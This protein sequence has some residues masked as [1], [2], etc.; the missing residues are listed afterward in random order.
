MAQPVLLAID[1]QER[2]FQAM[3]EDD[4]SS[5]LKA[6][7]A[8]ILLA[9][10]EGWEVWVTE[11]YPK[12][13]G[14]TIPEIH[15]TFLPNVLRFEKTEFDACR[16]PDFAHKLENLPLETHFF[17]V[18]IEAHVCVYLTAM[19]LKAKG[20]AVTVLADVVASRR[21]LCRSLSL[22]A[23]ATQDIRILPYETILFEA[24]RASTHPAFRKISQQIR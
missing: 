5:L 7:P 11:Q 18:G 14:P 20:F 13:L 24:L 8:L 6:V 15:D 3:P 22:D 10:H 16:N 2:L 9:G 23:L 1:I 4:R 21:A 19:S 17:V 12:G